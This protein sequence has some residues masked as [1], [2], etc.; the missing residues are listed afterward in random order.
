MVLLNL[1]PLEESGFM[2]AYRILLV[3]VALCVP[4]VLWAAGDKV[5]TTTQ[6]APIVG[7][8]AT[9]TVDGLTIQLDGGGNMTFRPH[10][11]R[12][13]EYNISTQDWV[14]GMEFFD[15]G[16]FDQAY[17]HLK[18]LSENVATFRE[19][20]RPMLFRNLG[21]A[22]M[23]IN[24][25]QE[26]E[27]ALNKVVKDYTKSRQYAEALDLLAQMNIELG[28]F[29]QVPP[30]L[31]DMEKLPGDYKFRAGMLKG[32]MLLGQG[33]IDEALN[34]FNRVATQAESEETRALAS[35]GAARCNVDKKDFGKALEMAQRALSNA[36]KDQVRAAS[37]LII[38]KAKL[39]QAES[40]SGPS[41]ETQLDDAALE[42]LRV[43]VL[44]GDFKEYVPE[45]LFNAGECY[46]LL[47]TFDNR[48]GDK[49]RAR[50]LYGTVIRDYGNSTFAQQAKDQL[51][52][53]R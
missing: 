46:R 24:Q 48:T 17:G 22:A 45:A 7:T 53:V 23:R 26:A 3:M 28:R 14:R 29:R 2:L 40:A 8:I 43:P 52:L 15:R 5:M 41:K 12:K 1:Q 49:N 42:F 50:T 9:D 33:K 30:L 18:V 19:A 4:S 47:A 27:A 6:A 21:E 16:Q 34:E 36:R 25:V 51:K 32:Q 35:L 20:A 39:K 38:G 11:I 31:E 13:I 37:H 44:Y 10:E